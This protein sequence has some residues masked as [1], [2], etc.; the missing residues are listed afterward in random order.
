MD[1]DRKI[2]GILY[3]LAK[4]VRFCNQ[5][6][7]CGE[8]IT[9]VQFNI[10]NH[11]YERGSMR[12]SD[13][14]QALSVEKSTTTRLVGPLVEKG[15]V[16]KGKAPD[17]SRAI[18]LVLTEAGVQSRNRAWDCLKGLVDAL[19]AGIPAAELQV[20]LDAVQRFISLLQGVCCSD[21]CCPSVVE[22]INDTGN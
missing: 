8:G 7:I 22:V 9:F 14:H 2:I 20:T 10:I 4:A 15:L 13:L 1:I 19:A 21:R 3:E 5:E 6:D 17:D 11:I 16:V 12:M 18:E